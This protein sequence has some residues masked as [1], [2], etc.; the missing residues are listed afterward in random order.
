MVLDGFLLNTLHYKVWI[1]GKRS[2]LGNGVKPL[3]LVVAATEKWAF[4]S[5]NNLYLS[6]RPYLKQGHFI[7][8]GDGHVQV[9]TQARSS[10]KKMLDL[11]SIFHFGA[12]QVLSDELKP[13][14]Q[15]L[16]GRGKGKAPE[17]WWFAL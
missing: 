1:K 16:P 2:N 9:E 14:K 3:Y 17:T 8:V 10:Q 6:N 7:V 12:S 15:V 5:P 4:R 11:V 13:T